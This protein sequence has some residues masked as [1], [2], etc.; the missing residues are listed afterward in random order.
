MGTYSSNYKLYLPGDADFVDV[1]A[2]VSNNMSIIDEA[3]YEACALK[4]ND[5]PFSSQSAPTYRLNQHV[6][7][8]WNGGIRVY[9][10][11]ANNDTYAT[12]HWQTTHAEPVEWTS[13]TPLLNKGWSELPG[14]KC[15]YR[16]YKEDVAPG[17]SPSYE[18]VE[19]M[20]RLMLGT[21]YSAIAQNTEYQICDYL[22]GMFLTQVPAAA[23]GSW[24]RVTMGNSPS[25]STIYNSG[26]VEQAP[27]L[28]NGNGTYS[29]ALS[30]YRKAGTS[31][32]ATQTAGNTEN[33]ICLDGLR[34][35]V[36]T[37]GTL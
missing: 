15:Y 2:D 12:S 17:S 30:F 11:K 18:H 23:F 20:G 36:S 33:Y 5:L 31:G 10:N 37:G 9:D 8:T 1:T 16:L 21:N 24:Q 28:V 32:A 14:F 25:S 3:V 22:P 35:V 26:Y 27:T 6:Y 19:F 29:F 34:Y 13:M 7:S 4:I